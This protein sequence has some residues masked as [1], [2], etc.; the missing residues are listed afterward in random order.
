VVIP[1][2]VSRLSGKE[3]VIGPS[4]MSGTC[5]QCGK[6][7]G[8]LRRL[9]QA[10]RMLCPACRVEMQDLLEVPDEER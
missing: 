6:Q 7:S 3:T 9:T 4:G 8:S 10:E 2:A 1:L 5:E